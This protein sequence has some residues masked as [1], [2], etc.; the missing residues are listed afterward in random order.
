MTQS[1]SGPRSCLGFLCIIL[2]SIMV[3]D[4]L[5]PDQSRLQGN[6]LC[7]NDWIQLRKIALSEWVILLVQEVAGCPPPGAQSANTSAPEFAS[8]ANT[9]APRG[10]RGPWYQCA[11]KIDGPCTGRPDRSSGVFALGLTPSGTGLE[12]LSS[13]SIGLLSAREREQKV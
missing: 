4:G 2:S 13:K 6:L 12:V 3:V 10:A 9:S 1:G 11:S 5:G 7:R 8:S